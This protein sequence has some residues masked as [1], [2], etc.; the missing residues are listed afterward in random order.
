MRGLQKENLDREGADSGALSPPPGC[1]MAS[2]HVVMHIWVWGARSALG[3][4]LS[5]R[6]LVSPTS[7]HADGQEEV[8]LQ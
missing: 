1:E 2:P 5:S 7:Q 4:S 6:A 8:G 3:C